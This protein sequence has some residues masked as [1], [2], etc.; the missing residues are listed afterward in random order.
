MTDRMIQMMM[1]IH[2]HHTS[3]PVLRKK[4]V[5]DAYQH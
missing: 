5:P 3:D 2:E 4:F 1:D